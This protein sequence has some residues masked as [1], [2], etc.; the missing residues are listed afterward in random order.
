[1]NSS[2]GPPQLRPSSVSQPPQLLDIWQ[3]QIEDGAE[4]WAR[5]MAGSPVPFGLDPIAFWRPF[6]DQA[7][8]VWAQ[9][10]S[11]MPV[12]PDLIAQWKQF[13]DQWIETW[14]RAL[15]HVMGTEIFAQAFGR[16]LD[17][18][19]TVQAPVKKVGAQSM[20]T[21]LFALGLPSRAQ[22]T[23]VARQLV[24]MEERVERLEDSV[25]AVLEHLE[26]RSV[27]GRK[28]DRRTQ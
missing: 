14:S 5:M 8:T 10:M 28:D 19:L 26:A 15:G 1:V 23:G 22:V 11:Q 6:L 2:P 17:L 21:A 24:E 27:N 16:S 18:M 12:S 9:F 7:V 25:R 20:E 3:K 4:T 13:M